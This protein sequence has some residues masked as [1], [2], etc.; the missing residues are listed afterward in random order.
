MCLQK[1]MWETGSSCYELL[2]EC[3]LNA[4]EAALGL[5]DFPQIDQKIGLVW[6]CLQHFIVAV[7]YH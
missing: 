2:Y 6:I 1:E 4:D 7:Q 3:Y 5:Q